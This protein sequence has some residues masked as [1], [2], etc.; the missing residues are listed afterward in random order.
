MKDVAVIGYCR[1]GIAKAVRGALNQTH[2][3][4]LAAHVLR[5]VVER[6]GVEGAEIEDVVV[7]CGLPEGATGHNIGRNAA[8]EAGFGDAVPGATINRYCG[9]GLTAASIVA[10]R[11]ATGEMSVAIAAGVE[12]ISLVQFNLNLN[13]FFYEPLQQ[14]M[15]AVWWTMNQT[16][17]FVAK[18]YGIAREALDAYVVESQKRVAAATAAGKYA[19]EIVPFKTTMKVTDKA[20]GETR[21][22]EVTLDHDE[23]PR[24]GTTLEA[25]AALKPVLPGGTTTA[26]NASQLSDGAGAVV[27]MDA[28]LASRRGLKI[29]GLFRGM[30]LA[31]V[32]PEEMSIAITPA[33]R[34]LMKQHSLSKGD[35]DLWELHEAYAVTTLYNQAQLETP[36]EITNVNGGAIALGHPYGMSGIRY[37]GST[38]L[39]LGRRD[40]HRAIVGVCTAGGMATAAYLER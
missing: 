2:G 33:I 30:Q 25:L 40:R 38:L 3:I 16:A 1:T 9:S 28:A 5:K 19:A 36:W 6:A 22:V 13:G 7:G 10:N 11:I 27:M 21:D 39:E 31:A 18:K 26:G 35:V 29:L 15:P 8:L 23:G 37:L 20:S 32:A 14:R 24:P 4:P 17:D 34:K 12:S